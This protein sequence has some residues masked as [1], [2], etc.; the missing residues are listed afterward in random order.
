MITKD[1]RFHSQIRVNDVD[2][3]E[4]VFRTHIL[5]IMHE[6]RLQGV[7]LLVYETYR[8]RERQELLYATGATQ[9]R[10]VGVHHFGLAC[11]L[12]MDAH[13]LPS[14]EGDFSILGR[15]A[16]TRNLIWGGDWGSPAKQNNFYDGA[17]LQRCTVFRQAELF[18]L[19]WYPDNKYN[20]LRDQEIY[21]G[22]QPE[23]L[24]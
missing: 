24:S 2:L 13:G 11:D 9:L 5:G 12:V 23:I 14:W 18:N 17:H 7:S 3:L 21:E 19:E 4:P 16:R 20:A 10:E 8:S 15:L 1:A 22:G 6:A